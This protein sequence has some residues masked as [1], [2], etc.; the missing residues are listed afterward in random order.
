MDTQPPTVLSGASLSSELPESSMA[1]PCS[2]WQKDKVG[3][4]EK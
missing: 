4:L 1:E 3:V 2:F